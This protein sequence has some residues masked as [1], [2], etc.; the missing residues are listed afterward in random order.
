[1]KN[2]KILSGILCT[3]IVVF[4]FTCVPSPVESQEDPGLT[5][6]TI[7]VGMLADLSGPSSFLGATCYDAVRTY[8]SRVNDQGGVHGRKIELVVVDAAYDLPRH[9][10]GYKRLTDKGDAFV[11]IS[12]GTPSTVAIVPL[13]AKDGIPM[14]PISATKIMFEPLKKSI[15]CL[16]TSYESTAQVIGDYIGEHAKGE[17][18]KVG[19]IYQDDDY[20][21]DLVNGITMQQKFW[22]Y[23]IVSQQAYKKGATDLTTQVLNVRKAEVEFLGLA[24]ITNETAFVRNLLN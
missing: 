16:A 13:V 18:A 3:I 2:S 8:F 6:T 10:A 5:G 12:W 1:M 14:I 21:A 24:T 20:G 19:I 15:F 11:L 17:A 7:K 22:K 9:V 4:G 23:H